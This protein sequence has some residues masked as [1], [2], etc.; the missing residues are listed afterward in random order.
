MG[1]GI[2]RSQPIRLTHWIFFLSAWHLMAQAGWGFNEDIKLLTEFHNA[3]QNK[4]NDYPLEKLE[5]SLKNI[6]KSDNEEEIKLYC[7]AGLKFLLASNSLYYD[8]LNNIRINIILKANKLSKEFLT[9]FALELA[10]YPNKDKSLLECYEFLNE[11]DLESAKI[12]SFVFF[13]NLLYGKVYTKDDIKKIIHDDRPLIKK[14][15]KILNKYPE[16]TQKKIYDYLYK[17]ISPET[18]DKKSFYYA[19]HLFE[20][21]RSSVYSDVLERA[22]ID[23]WALFKIAFD[24][25]LSFDFYLT[26]DL[27]NS[28]TRNILEK[29]DIEEIEQIKIPGLKLAT[30]EKM[31]DFEINKNKIVE[32]LFD[33]ANKNAG[34]DIENRRTKVNAALLLYDLNL[35]ENKTLEIDQFSAMGDD[36]LSKKNWHLLGDITR[37]L[38]L[39]Q[40][41]EE[42]LKYAKKMVAYLKE[43]RLLPSHAKELIRLLISSNNRD[44]S[45]AGM[46]ICA[47]LLYFFPRPLSKHLIFSQQKEHQKLV[48]ESYRKQLKDYGV[49]VFGELL[50]LKEEFAQKLTRKLG[51][52][53]FADT[54]F[55][56]RLQ[57]AVAAKESDD[58]EIFSAAWQVILEFAEADPKEN[59][60]AVK[61]LCECQDPEW[62]KHG[63][64]IYAKEKFS[65]KDPC[66][67][68]D[69]INHALSCFTSGLLHQKAKLILFE[70]SKNEEFHNKLI[71]SDNYSERYQSLL[72]E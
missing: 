54:E 25:G 8:D 71:H 43:K 17:K 52:E 10:S 70:K 63:V 14:M 22:F 72:K 20:I 57:F 46:A 32:I 12:E 5:K 4:V 18:L 68:F 49:E 9:S 61:T 28:M 29:M 56:N 59:W 33:L 58:K 6:S 53:I 23:A 69:E 26:N 15:P 48:E 16:E 47:E 40:K 19:Q 21:F 66:D 51:L 35:L 11:L 31:L 67:L 3:S 39:S 24:N 60:S 34:D 55:E 37:I 36:F 38:L 44:I 50:D 64:E 45:S 7:R 2:V 65:K 42:G 41:K 1:Y 30:C 62:A 27:A 13:F